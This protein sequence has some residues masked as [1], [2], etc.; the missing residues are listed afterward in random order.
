M[1]F[2]PRSRRHAAVG[3]L[4][5]LAVLGASSIAGAQGQ[6][7]AGTTAPAPLQRD[8]AAAAAEFQVPQP[9]L[10]ALSYTLTRWEDGG[11]R[12]DSTGGYGPMHLVLQPAPATATTGRRDAA[13]AVDTLDAAAALT[14]A[15]AGQV[16]R[17]PKQN[18]RAG[19]ALL[20]SY[21]GS[22]RPGSLDGWYPAVARYSGGGADSASGRLLADAVFAT[23]RAGATA[24][25]SDGT[26][27]TLA[28]QPGVTAGAEPAGGAAQCPTSLHCVSRT[29]AGGPQRTAAQ[30]RYLVL[31]TGSSTAEQ[32]IAA[33]LAPR[34]AMTLSYVVRDDG[35]VTQLLPATT[36]PDFTGNATI[37]GAAI[38]I[39]V[40]RPAAPVA[41]YPAAT[42][43]GLAALLRYLG[44]TYHIPLDRQHVLDRSEIPAASD[45]VTATA[46][47]RPAAGVGT[48]FDWARALQLAG[49]DLAGPGD[50]FGHVVAITPVFAGNRQQGQVCV[51]AVGVDCHPAGS[52]P[53]NFVRLH[54][55]PSTSAPLVSDPALHPDGAAGSTDLADTGDQAVA[56]QLYAVAEHRPGWTGI[57]YGGQVAWLQDGTGAQGVT[58]QVRSPLVTP[59]PGLGSA[60][61]YTEPGTPD[62]AGRF[63]AA[64]QSYPLLGHF[65]GG[66]DLIGF[67]PGVAF[68]RGADLAEWPG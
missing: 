21:A 32:L 55:E 9:L 1:R 20:A 26:T 13:P 6:R 48:A 58:R 17:D 29:G 38:A 49:G 14:G 64:A 54:T 63:L 4:I 57:Y 59:A 44:A 53:A 11:G 45:G 10:L 3:A 42:Y 15:P 27:M 24:T 68:V 19:A 37:D 67:G 66:W 28:A 12:P 39:A 23:L 2:V 5:G 31:G 47:T 65:P 7:R 8:F 33:Q 25:T 46:G 60:A 41:P 56:G 50:D 51:A 35:Q 34:P 22:P 18:I 40:D 36:A 62:P 52:H 16:A 30:I 61:V 43:R